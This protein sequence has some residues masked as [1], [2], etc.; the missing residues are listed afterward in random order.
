MPTI[1][2]I[3]AT[4]TLDG[5]NA[6]NQPKIRRVAGYA[7]VST[8]SE[9]QNTSYIAQIEYYASYIKNHPDWEF[10]K[11]Y[12]DEGISGT[13]TARRLGFNQMITD[14]LSGQIDLIVTKSVSRFA[15]NTV[16]SLTTIR[17]LKEKQVECYFE[18]ENIWTFDGKGELLITIMSSIAQEESRSISENVTWSKRKQAKEGKVSFNYPHFLGYDKGP[19]GK[20]VINE[21]QAETVRLIY[22]LFL[23]GKSVNSIAVLL[24]NKGFPTPAGKQKWRDTC[25]S[26][27]LQNEKY[28]GDALLQ[29]RF[30][31]DYLTHKLKRNEGEVPQYYV[32]KHHEPI[33][34][35]EVHALVQSEFERRKG[36][37]GKLNTKRMLSGRMRCAQCGSW[38]GRKIWHA[39]SPS[40][41]VVW[42]CNGKYDK[43]HAQCTTGN[44]TEYWVKEMFVIALDRLL[45]TSPD[46]LDTQKLLYN[47]SFDT[48]LLQK[49]RRKLLTEMEITAKLI[50][51][52]TNRLA[53]E[54]PEEVPYDSDLESLQIRYEGLEK[55]TSELNAKIHNKLD[56]KV[57]AT[58]FFDKL[59]NR[60]KPISNFNIDLWN[61]LLDHID[62]YSQNDVRFLFRDGSE[63]KVDISE[64]ERKR[65]A[66]TDN[67]KEQIADL[68]RSGLIY[69]KIASKMSLTQGQVRSYCLSRASRQETNGNKEFCKTCGKVLVHTPGYRKKIFCC[70]GCR[71]DWWNRSIQSKSEAH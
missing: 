68:R 2:V 56:K 48:A 41:K 57:I 66:L 12:T 16:D 40:Q 15:R 36:M 51:R 38:F 55:R 63:I 50:E 30:T 37:T 13:S 1:R 23:Q 45:K 27:I 62:V 58:E 26:S 54:E 39:N 42:Q 65:P 43:S 53:Q 28:I 14:A 67:Q 33:I 17:K 59:K 29:K 21:Q 49:K 69:N 35:R 11:V 5:N 6:D 60:K 44:I 31:V 19:D 22:S 47:A 32:E 10:V 64:E 25:V 8:D 71:S 18:K 4:K 70:D 9:E 7:R 20:L 34:S 46:I 52:I 3:P 61:G 24:T